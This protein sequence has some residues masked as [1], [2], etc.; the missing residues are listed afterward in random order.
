[1]AGVRALSD[2]V[3][4]VR[5]RRIAVI[6]FLLLAAASAAAQ[7]VKHPL[8]GLTASDYWTVYDVMRASRRVDA[9]TRYPFITLHEPPK[10]EVLQWKPGQSFRREALVV[11]K[12]GSRTFEA[13]VDIPGGKIVSWKEMQ[14]I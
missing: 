8:D 4:S 3:G 5:T 1:M 2:P 10:D 12:Q 13:V 9:K 14:G 11:V 7:S 6:S